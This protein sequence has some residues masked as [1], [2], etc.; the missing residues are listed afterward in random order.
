MPV[1]KRCV[2]AAILLLARGAHAHQAG[3]SQGD[4]LL[5]G[6]TLEAEV[7]LATPE[8]RAT[9]LS[10]QEVVAGIEVRFDGTLVAGRLVAASPVEGD[11]IAVI[12]RY[13][14]TAP[15]GRLELSFQL[16]DRVGSEHR[17]VAHVVAGTKVADAILHR[18]DRA[19][20]MEIGAP[21]PRSQPARI[22]A[23]AAS[24]ALLLALLLPP[25]PRRSLVLVGAALAGGELLAAALGHAL[26]LRPPA[27]AIPVA[28]ALGALF[29]GI[30]L[31]AAPLAPQRAWVALFL[32]LVQGLDVPAGAPAGQG[33]VA[34]VLVALGPA[35]AG[36]PLRSRWLPMGAGLLLAIAALWT[37]RAAALHA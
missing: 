34:L 10:P 35:L 9:G 32:G 29:V 33:L 3:V 17:H 20:T 37:I 26:A 4:Y 8:M 28:M 19:V 11:G 18:T 15:P 12:A 22:P 23:S 6:G 5:R 2:A 30:E 27:H 25:A 14:G 36:T 21:G 24:A 16:A 1:S 13:E 7:V 31:V